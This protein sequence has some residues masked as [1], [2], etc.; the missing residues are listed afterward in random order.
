MRATLV[1]EVQEQ[2]MP[3]SL[4]CLCSVVGVDN[5]AASLAHSQT[6]DHLR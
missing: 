6:T 5:C 1:Q 2:V 3:L 4:L